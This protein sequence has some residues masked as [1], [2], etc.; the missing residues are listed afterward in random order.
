MEATRTLKLRIKDKHASVLDRMAREVNLVWNFANETSSR[1][2]RERHE[3]LS[4]FDLQKLTAG[5][6]KEEGVLVGS[7]TVQQVCE[8]YATRRKQFKKARL[9]WRVSNPKSS[10]RSLGWVPFKQGA[11]KYKAGQV[12]FAGYK[13][14]L[15]D[16]YG[17]GEP[18]LIIREK[19]RYWHQVLSV[20]GSN[21][22]LSTAS[23]GV[24][25]LNTAA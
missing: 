4:G 11:V 17:L 3:W 20:S 1:A 5:Y 9:N 15:W 22:D 6:V 8:E 2:I 24:M 21:T 25:R 18:G 7:S 10:K 16:S 13:L 23:W 19:G 12:A 14:S